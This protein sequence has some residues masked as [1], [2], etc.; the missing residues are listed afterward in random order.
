MPWNT[1]PTNPVIGPINPGDW[2]TCLP[3]QNQDNEHVISFSFY[4]ILQF[5][6]NCLYDAC[7]EVVELYEDYF[8]GKQ[9]HI[10]L[11]SGRVLYI[12][13]PS[14]IVIDFRLPDVDYNHVYITFHGIKFNI[15][16]FGIPI[17]NFWHL[18]FGWL[19]IPL[20]D[21]TTQYFQRQGEST[22]H[23]GN[24]YDPVEKYVLGDLTL[25]VS[26][27]ALIAY[28]SKFL[29][30]SGFHILSELF[31]RRAIKCPTLSKTGF[32][33]NVTSSLSS[34]SSNVSKI[35]DATS[36]GALKTISTVLSILAKI[37]DLMGT[38][39]IDLDEVNEDLEDIE[40]KIDELPRYRPYG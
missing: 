26:I 5:I 9:W 11:P 14:G 13:N 24:W 4:K 32:H 34:L 8:E 19:N 18:F 3:I 29:L 23:L 35:D 10:I 27:A 12:T 15:P 40:S 17:I 37:E 39:E 25:D 7:V 16:H 28:I 6:F 36:S 33:S 38:G 20:G 1:L 2:G 22:P 31:N 21:Y 30:T